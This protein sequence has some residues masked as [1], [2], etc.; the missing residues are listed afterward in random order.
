MSRIMKGCRHLSQIKDT[1][2][3]I[4]G[5]NYSEGWLERGH[6]GWKH[7][8]FEG[9]DGAFDEMCF[10]I[11]SQRSAPNSPQWFNTGLH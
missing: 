11:A 2:E 1:L 10:L 5:E 6:W 4:M 9:A 3:K 7:G 8:Y